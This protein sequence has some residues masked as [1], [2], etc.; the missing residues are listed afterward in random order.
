MDTFPNRLRDA[1]DRS[2]DLAPSPEFISRLRKD[3]E[4]HAQPARPHRL[5]A[6]HWVALA[7]SLLVVT[8][9]TATYW[10]YS[11]SAN[12]L[13]RA[14]VGDHVECAL[15]MNLPERGIS[16]EEAASRFGPAFRAIQQVPAVN[17]STA[18]GVAHVVDRHS[19]VYQG[20]R[21]GHVIL[22]YRGST[23]SLMVAP[24]NQ[25]VAARSVHLD[26][27]NVVTIRAGR[28]ALFIAGDLPMNDLSTLADAIFGP[29]A[30]ELGGA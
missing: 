25:G 17:V 9:I 11:T 6:S 29:L 30:R 10:V 15:K 20:R 23:V 12:A 24:A 19:C 7:A 18:A 14:A 4:E 1:I 13:A 22:S 2:P 3:L 16:L 8:S 26:G 27:M 5:R 21:F 28:Q